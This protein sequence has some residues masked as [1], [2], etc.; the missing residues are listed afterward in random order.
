VGESFSERR[1]EEVGATPVEE[2]RREKLRRF[3]MV[4]KSIKRWVKWRVVGAMIGGGAGYGLYSSCEDE[5]P[6]HRPIQ[7]KID[8]GERNVCFSPEVNARYEKAEKQ[9]FI[10]V[11]IH[12]VLPD[13][14]NFGGVY[15]EFAEKGMEGLNA[16][17]K[18]L[19]YSFYVKEV[20]D[21]HS[22]A[23]YNRLEVIKATGSEEAFEKMLEDMGKRQSVS[24]TLNIFIVPDIGFEVYGRSNMDPGNL[25]QLFIGYDAGKNPGTFFAHEVG[26]TFGLYH[27]HQDRI[28]GNKDC[29]TEG[30]FLCD[31]P[32]DPAPYNS[33]LN[34]EGCEVDESCQI[35]RCGKDYAGK[36]FMEQPPLVE[37]LMSYYNQCHKSFTSSQERVM[38][39]T[40]AKTK[41][42]LLHDSPESVS[43]IIQTVKVKCDAASAATIQEGIDRITDMGGGKV[44]VCAGTYHES[45]EIEG[46]RMT[47][48]W[49]SDKYALKLTIEPAKDESGHDQKVIIDGDNARRFVDVP[50]PVVGLSVKNISSVYLTL[51]GMTFTHGYLDGKPGHGMALMNFSGAKSVTLDRVSVTDSTVKLH[52][53]V[54]E[55]PVNIS[56]ISGCTFSG[57]Q[58]ERGHLIGSYSSFSVT[59]SLF[60]DNSASVKDRWTDGSDAALFSVSSWNPING[61][62]RPQVRFSGVRYD[63]NEMDGVHLTKLPKSGLPDDQYRANVRKKAYVKPVYEAVCSLDDVECK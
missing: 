4:V 49:F 59:D 54:V 43:Q 13:G 44:Q 39:C 7:V 38:A 40:V 56:T 33:V 18:N 16:A 36:S 21:V 50:S 51:R 47:D 25:S 32:A 22:S 48:Q 55:L 60:K 8:A 19:R 23:V 5:E 62:S 41:Q 45:L 58:L 3:G 14:G 10:P 6:I 57:N 53:S 26:H 31:T 24:G 12:R 35:K 63:G 15:G 61:E 30:D 27:P 46:L 9:Q 37:N 34:P 17:F 28:A 42:E 11:T 2:P 52:R 1:S 29:A 20:R